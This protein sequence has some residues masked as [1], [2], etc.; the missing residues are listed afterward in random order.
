MDE[1]FRCVISSN[2]LA[3]L[4]GLGIFLLTAFLV[5]RNLIG[6][7]TSLIF[8]V[9]ALLAALG[10]ANHETVKGKLDQY[11]SAPTAQERETK[12][13]TDL[14]KA[15]DD[16]KAEFLEYKKQFEDYIKEQTAKKS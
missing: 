4:T 15:F 9:F 8:L 16:L 2:G 13:N 11:T 14:Q 12:I 5:A 7:T 10:I 3:Y 6:F 1:F